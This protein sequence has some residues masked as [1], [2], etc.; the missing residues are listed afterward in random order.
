MHQEQMDTLPGYA[1]TAAYRLG[2]L[3]STQT[4]LCRLCLLRLDVGSLL[5]CNELPSSVT[6]L[7]LLQVMFSHGFDD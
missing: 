1:Q 7:G 4:I 6:A 3:S 2:L 5:V